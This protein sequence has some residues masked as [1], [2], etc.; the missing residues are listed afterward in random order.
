MAKTYDAPPDRQAV[1]CESW[2]VM[3]SE[4]WGSPDWSMTRMVLLIVSIDPDGTRPVLSDTHTSVPAG[5]L[6]VHE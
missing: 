3:G 5:R 1:D 4:Y 2:M 6:T